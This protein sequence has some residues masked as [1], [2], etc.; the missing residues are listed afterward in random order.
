MCFGHATAAPR[1]KHNADPRECW[2]CER[3]AEARM[4]YS[5]MLAEYLIA[6]GEMEPN[7]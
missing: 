6:K 5:D 4:D 7:E 2:K 3:E 1:C